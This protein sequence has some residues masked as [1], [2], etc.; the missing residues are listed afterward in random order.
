MG[1]NQIES[2]EKRID[3]IERKI[4]RFQ[5]MKENQPEMRDTMVDL[6]GKIQNFNH[7]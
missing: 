7:R 5:I 6:M 3:N 1:R 2:L 4:K